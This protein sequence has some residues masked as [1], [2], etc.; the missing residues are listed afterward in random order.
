MNEDTK[1]EPRTSHTKL[2]KQPS[3]ASSVN[4]ALNCLYDSDECSHDEDNEE[5]RIRKGRSYYF[6]PQKHSA[7]VFN[8]EG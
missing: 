1:Q 7:T 2:R 8:G 4:S 5:E 6:L 3:I